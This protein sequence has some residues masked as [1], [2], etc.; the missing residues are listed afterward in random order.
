MAALAAMGNEINGFTRPKILFDC[1][2]ILPVALAVWQMVYP[3]LC[4]WL[5][6]SVPTVLLSGTWSF[7]IVY[8]VFNTRLVDLFRTEWSLVAL[9]MCGADVLV[10]VALI[11]ACPKSSTLARTA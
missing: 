1:L 11:Y 10:S 6:F 3:T 7:Y 4:G 2:L 9:I 8:L 5:V